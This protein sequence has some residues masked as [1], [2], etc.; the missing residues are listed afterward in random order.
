M[1]GDSFGPTSEKTVTGC[2][3]VGAVVLTHNSVNDLLSSLDGLIS[4][5]SIE[6][7]I[8]VVDNASIPTN[9]AAMEE[10]FR[11]KLPAGIIVDAVDAT[12]DLLDFAH[13]VFVRSPHNLGYSVGN[14]IG[15]RLAVTAGCEAVLIVNPDVRISNPDYLASLWS[16]MQKVPTCLVASSRI[17]DL[18]GRDEHPLRETGFWEEL[19][20]FRQL[21]PRIFRPAT[22]VIPPS[23]SKPVEAEKLHG[24]CLLLR[25]SFLEA[26]NFLDEKV[27]L[28]SEE[29][30]LAAQVRSVGGRMIVFPELEAVHAHV[31][32]AKGNPSHRMLQFI[33]SR[34][35]YL[36][37]YTNYGPIRSTA[38]HTSYGVL[39][40]LYRMKAW[41]GKR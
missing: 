13:A 29:P 23:G 38:L 21:G 16:E 2:L 15:A 14:N 18:A 40:L 6:I 24:S 12:S 26:T 7:R 30:I 41:S 1:N 25:A 5:R 33:T 19:L 10:I 27:F 20:W 22:R 3:M 8:I 11:E 39:S 4:Q 37:T 28:Y 31:T 35:Y 9:R 32:S 36:D 34:L 17:F